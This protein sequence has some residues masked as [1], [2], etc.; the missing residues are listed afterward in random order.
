MRPTSDPIFD[1]LSR[2]AAT[3][4]SP[5]DPAHSEVMAAIYLLLIDT[6]VALYR[7]LAT[8]DAARSRRWFVTPGTTLALSATWVLALCEA[9]NVSYEAFLRYAPERWEADLKNPRSRVYKLNHDEIDLY[10]R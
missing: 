3:G 1:L 4:R 10:G 6:A 8:S 9:C 2:V 5:D 7:S